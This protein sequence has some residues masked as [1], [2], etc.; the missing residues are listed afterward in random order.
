MESMYSMSIFIHLFGVIGF[1]SVALFSLFQLFA[2]NDVHIYAKKMRIVMP[3][4]S[5]FIVVLIFTGAIMMA[6]KHLSF[7]WQNI[8][9]ILYSLVLIVLETKRYVMLKHLNIAL[10]GAFRG[11]RQKAKQILMLHVVMTLLISGAMYL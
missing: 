1:L 8:V 6:A 5:M 4:S 9:M 3:I 7:S 10:D 2:Y 11:Y